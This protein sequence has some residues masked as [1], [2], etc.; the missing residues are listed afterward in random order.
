MASWE[1]VKS[2]WGTY[3]SARTPFLT[4]ARRLQRPTVNASVRCLTMLNFGLNFGEGKIFTKTTSKRPSHLSKEGHALRKAV[5]VRQS[6]RC[7]LGVIDNKPSQSQ[8][9]ARL[10]FTSTK[11]SVSPCSATGLIL[12]NGSNSG[13]PKSANG[14]LLNS[15]QQI[16]RPLG[17]FLES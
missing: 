14:S 13:E 15:P 8:L 17:Q 5:A 6:F 4:C 3:R 16:A 1:P 12:P 11:L 9:L 2:S 7:L 10:A